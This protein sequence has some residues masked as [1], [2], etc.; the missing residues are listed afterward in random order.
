MGRDPAA[1]AEQAARSAE[2][3]SGKTVVATAPFGIPPA[4]NTMADRV[5]DAQAIPDPIREHGSRPHTP[6]RGDQK[7]QRP[8]DP[9]LC[10]QRNPAERF[11]SK[12]KRFR[13]IATRYGKRARNFLSAIALACTKLWARHNEH[14]T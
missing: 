2:Q 8:V 5:H 14:T 4:Q 9:A 3:V 12:L 6:A 10:Q 1:A 11:L 7:G 13:G